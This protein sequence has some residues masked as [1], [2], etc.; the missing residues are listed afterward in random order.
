VEAWWIARHE[1]FDACQFNSSW[2]GVP[3]VEHFVPLIGSTV[4]TVPPPHDYGSGIQRADSVAAGIN[5]GVKMQTPQGTVLVHPNSAFAGNMPY[6]P[7]GSLPSAGIFTGAYVQSDFPRVPPPIAATQSFPTQQGRD[8][9]LT[10]NG[11]KVTGDPGKPTYVSV[12]GTNATATW[13]APPE[14]TSCATMVPGTLMIANT[15]TWL[16][17]PPSGSRGIS[18]VADPRAGRR[19]IPQNVTGRFTI[20]CAGPGYLPVVKSAMV[21]GQ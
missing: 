10:I 16:R 5:C 14:Y 19:G 18:L 6:T 9:N 2:S 17:L 13:Q 1:S 7:S 21:I 3:I 12:D 4:G 20:M 15:A 11:T 8:I